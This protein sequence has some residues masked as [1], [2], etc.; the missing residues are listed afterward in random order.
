MESVIPTIQ[1]KIHQWDIIQKVGKYLI[2]M[3][4]VEYVQ[5]GLIGQIL[6][7]NLKIGVLAVIIN[8]QQDQD[9]IQKEKYGV[10]DMSFSFKK[11]S[12]KLLEKMAR[13][14]V[15]CPKCDLYFKGYTDSSNICKC[16]G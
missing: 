5:Y 16:E 13:D 1:V 2:R 10:K 3:V 7:E 11:R 14:M 4:I 15:I 8:Y 9:L 6:G 12:K